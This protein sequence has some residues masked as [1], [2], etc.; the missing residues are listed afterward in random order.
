MY[1][2]TA[3]SRPM[4][5]NIDRKGGPLRRHDPSDPIRKVPQWLWI[6][7]VLVAIAHVGAIA[8]GFATGGAYLALALF[9]GLM[10]LALGAIIYAN[11]STSRDRHRGGA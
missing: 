9:G 11:S 4:T 1:P 2:G 3:G 5:P 8:Y 6:V 10:L 7:A